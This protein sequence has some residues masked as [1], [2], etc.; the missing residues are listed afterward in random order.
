VRA[1]FLLP[2]KPMKEFKYVITLHLENGV[3]CEHPFSVE[4]LYELIRQA[5]EGLREHARLSEPP[6]EALR[7]FLALVPHD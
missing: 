2:G 6:Q 3:S 4:D 1:P 7:Q 5:R